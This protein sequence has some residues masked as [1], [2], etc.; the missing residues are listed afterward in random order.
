MK[1]NYLLI[2]A[3]LSPK[4]ALAGIYNCT[5]QAVFSDFNLVCFKSL[6]VM[7]GTVDTALT[8]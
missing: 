8:D 5:F 3:I 1:L 4:C 6:C 7:K 2:H